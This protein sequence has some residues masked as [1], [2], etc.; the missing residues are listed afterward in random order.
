[1]LTVES[2]GGAFWVARDGSR[3]SCLFPTRDAA[4]AELARLRAE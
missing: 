2:A 4:D 1:M 3:V